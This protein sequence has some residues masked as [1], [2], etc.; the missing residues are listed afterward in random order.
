MVGY[1]VKPKTGPAPAPVPSNYN[2]DIR[3]GLTIRQQANK[4]A[5]TILILAATKN[6]KT[7]RVPWSRTCDVTIKQPKLPKHVRV[8][9]GEFSTF[10]GQERDLDRGD[11]PV[12]RS[13]TTL[14]YRRQRTYFPKASYDGW[15]K[16]ARQQTQR[17]KFIQIIS[18]D[19]VVSLLNGLG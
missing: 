11:Q 16:L 8:H 1:Y 17:I 4:E 3:I 9:I 7:S 5:V 2:R 18:Y 14:R 6:A 15:P 12:H 10:P 19:R 13:D